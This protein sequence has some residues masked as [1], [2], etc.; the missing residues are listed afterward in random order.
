LVRKA[1]HTGSRSR[2]SAKVGLSPGTPVFIGE[3]KRDQVRIDVMAYSEHG[4]EESQQV[5]V[6]ECAGLAN[7]ASVTW[8]NVSGIHD[9]DMIA[10]LGKAFNLHPLTLEDLVNTTHRPKTEEFPDYLFVVLKMMTY[11]ETSNQ[12]DVEHVSLIL[13]ENYVISFLE[14]EGDVFDEVRE[15]IRAAKSR[16]R[17]L[18]SDYLAY[19]LIDAVVDHY[20]LA[21]ERIGDVIEEIDERILVDPQP[22]DIHEIHRLKRGMMTLRKA[23]WPLR[24]EIGVLEKSQSPLIRQDTRMYLRDLY[25]HTIQ[26]VDMVESFRDLLGGMHDTYLSSISTRMNEI[27]KVLTIIATIFIPLTFL[28]GVYGMNFEHMPE[29]KWAWGYYLIWGVMIALGTGM[30]TY[31]RRK[32]WL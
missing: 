31:F 29:L 28:V 12:I 2:L 26:V 24:E 11:N 15:R 14:N 27:M 22:V 3:Q 21:L 17:S 25:A 19:S 10:A 6:A 8:V 16:M 13:G 32:K 5:R 20:F 18:Q 23:V 30:L 9:L 1:K 7:A 4:L